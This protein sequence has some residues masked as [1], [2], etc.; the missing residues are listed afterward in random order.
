M[1]WEVWS[2][3][4]SESMISNA[5]QVSFR[6]EAWGIFVRISRRFLEPEISCLRVRLAYVGSWRVDR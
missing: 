6:E 4:Q 1:F 2:A 3:A 5:R